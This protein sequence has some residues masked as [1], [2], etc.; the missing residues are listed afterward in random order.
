MRLL[1]HAHEKENTELSPSA[2]IIEREVVQ[3]RRAL[4][5][6]KNDLSSARRAAHDLNGELASALLEVARLQ[7]AASI[8]RGS[9][10]D[11]FIIKATARILST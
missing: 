6:I 7:V 11:E 10:G 3:T 1:A 8:A 4:A 2:A 5:D 9:P